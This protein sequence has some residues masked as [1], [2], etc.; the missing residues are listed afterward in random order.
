MTPEGLTK[1]GYKIQFGTNH[2]GP[3]LF[4]QLLLPALKHTATINSEVRVIFLSSNLS[5]SAPKNTY[6]L[7]DLKTTM[8]NIATRHRYSISK[9]A[10]IHYAAAFAERHR[11]L[12][13]IS[14]HPGIV[15][16]NLTG[17]LLDSYPG[18]IRKGIELG[19]KATPITV[20]KGALNQLWAATSAEART[21]VF[22]YP[23]GM[24]SKGSKLSENEE[25]REKL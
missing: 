25:Q 4:T 3:A 2:M 21:S 1:E 6:Q 12:K 13:C 10:N 18:L 5:H 23:V 19:L 17:P 20:D 8:P 14:V 11:E 15:L 7:R 24:A 22:Y 16:T 9:V